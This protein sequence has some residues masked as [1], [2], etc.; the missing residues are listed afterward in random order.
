MNFNQ[1]EYFVAAAE[2][3]NFTEAGK[4]LHV[5]QTAIT[6]QIKSLETELEVN[7]FER[8]GRR[9]KLTKAGSVLLAETEE[10]LKA[11]ERAKEKTKRA[12]EGYVGMVNIGFLKGSEQ[13]GISTSFAEFRRLYPGIA[14]KFIRQD[15][16]ELF[17]SVGC[18]ACDLVLNERN[19][20]PLP[21]DISSFTYQEFAVMAIVPI[22]HPCAL[23]ES[24][25]WE[26][27][28]NDRIIELVTSSESKA[29]YE[30]GIA[31]SHAVPRSV[32]KAADAESIILATAS[33]M[34]IGFLPEYDLNL[35]IGI[36]SVRAIPLVEA[37]AHLRVYWKDGSDNS[38]ANLLKDYL[39]SVANYDKLH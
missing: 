37:K 10:V 6:Q 17:E 33:G 38:A 24:A 18:G 8:N 28:R 34:G 11:I 25:T 12:D 4:R 39:F 21:E 9:V 35:T 29:L 3:E 22:D 1:M 2:L 31:S 27:F 5:S 20:A 15:Y 16:A 23:K 32:T 14:F 13:T 19:I 26:D 30:D 7:L 36:P